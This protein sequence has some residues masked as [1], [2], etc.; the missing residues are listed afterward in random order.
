MKSLRLFL[1]RIACFL[2]GH[3]CEPTGRQAILLMEWKCK[4]CG[5]V[6]VSHAHYGPALIP[7][8]EGSDRIFR[9]FADAVKAS[10]VKP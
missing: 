2:R 3:P 9:D 8:N 6:Y 4:C 1:R 5:G 7:A 10:E